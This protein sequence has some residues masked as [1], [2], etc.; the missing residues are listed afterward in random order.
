MKNLFKILFLFLSLTLIQCSSDDDSSVSALTMNGTDF[1]LGS[2]N[3]NYIKTDANNRISFAIRE[4]VANNPRVIAVYAMH[5]PGSRSGTYQLSNNTVENGYA[6][7]AILNE[8]E[9]TQL[10]GGSMI[11]PPT[12]TIK[13]ENH[14]N[15]HMAVTFNDVVLDGGTATETTISGTCSKGFVV[16]DN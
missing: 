3:S 2:G 14:G 10:A 6:V 13:I 9:T 12:G 1:K 16:A 7:I 11:A 4:N 15:N 5:A 8:D